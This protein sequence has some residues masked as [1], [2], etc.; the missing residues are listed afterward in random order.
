M[1]KQCKSCGEIYDADIKFC[2]KCGSPIESM[3][4]EEKPAAGK[5]RKSKLGI[6][7]LI[8]VIVLAGAGSIIYTVVRQNDN[9][10]VAAD[11]KEDLEAAEEKASQRKTEEAKESTADA[12]E[13]A[14]NATADTSE[15]AK[16]AAGSS[17][18]AEKAADAAEETGSGVAGSSSQ[19]SVSQNSEYIIPDSSTRLLTA[20]DLNGLSKDELR[21]ARNEIFARYGRRF[22]DQEL[23]E[24]FDS[25]SWYKGTIDPDDFNDDT[26]SEIEKKNAELIQSY[27]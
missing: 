23:Q 2:I 8:G 13:E 7:V 18:D 20:A 1:R 24:Y 9:K 6:L 3:G 25:K 15:E 21:L 16:K 10:K 17:K 26:V 12:S 14:E 27:E 11:L 19:S 4:S 5:A 22:K